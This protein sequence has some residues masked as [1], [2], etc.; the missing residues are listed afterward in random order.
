VCTKCTTSTVLPR[1]NHSVPAIMGIR[2]MDTGKRQ[3][4]DPKTR[5]IRE[6]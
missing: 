2:A 3:V 1:F 5:R 4:Y 6:G